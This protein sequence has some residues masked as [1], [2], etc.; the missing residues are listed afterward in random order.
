MILEELTSPFNG[1][2]TVMRDL[3]WGTYIRAGGLTQSGGIVTDVWK[4][5][6][7]QISN[8]KFLASNV[9]IFGLGGG[10]V[11]S[12]VRKYWPDS[13]IKGVD[14]DPFMVDLGKKYLGLGKLN[15]DIVIEDASDFVKKEKGKYDL[16][17]IDMYK[18][19]NVPK[20]FEEVEF[21]GKVRN[22]LDEEGI[23]VFNRL[24]GP[25]DRPKSMEMGRKLETVFNKVEYIYPQANVMFICKR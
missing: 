25:N 21:I 19:E 8:S 7:T 22:M 18:G 15:I 4:R 20:E 10:S 13:Q 11:A 12:L 24:Y 9:L 6:I 1:K 23:A 2:L 16:V 3:A 17:C 14:I 5:T